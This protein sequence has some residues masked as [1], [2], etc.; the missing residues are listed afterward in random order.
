MEGHHDKKLFLDSFIMMDKAM[1]KVKAPGS[2][3]AGQRHGDG[4]PEVIFASGVGVSAIP[5]S[6]SSNDTR[7]CPPYIAGGGS[8]GRAP[9]KVPK[10]SQDPIALGAF[11]SD[12]REVES[13]SQS[14]RS[15]K[16]K[17]GERNL[18][19]LTKSV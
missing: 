17:K 7:P 5:L 12:G 1:K 14:R 9:A 10:G 4:A 3:V 11:T 8:T 18:Q 16:R 6:A 13:A 19:G 2:R 15:R